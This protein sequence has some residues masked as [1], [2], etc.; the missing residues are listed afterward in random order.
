M[1]EDDSTR[2]GVLCTGGAMNE[3]YKV[4]KARIQ[5]NVQKYSQSRIRSEK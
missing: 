1:R 3:I 2:K 5:I 4:C